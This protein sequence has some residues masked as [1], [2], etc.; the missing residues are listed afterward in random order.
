[1]AETWRN[2]TAVGG[3]PLAITDNLNFGNPEKPP[4]MGQIVEAI[5]GIGAACKGLDY[6]VIS[7][8]VSLYNET[9]GRPILPTPAIG[10]VGLLRDLN[11]AL[12]RS[13]VPRQMRARKNGAKSA[14]SLAIT[15]SWASNLGCSCHSATP[16]GCN[17]PR[18]RSR[19]CSSP[20]LLCVR[21]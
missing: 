18:T 4:I 16:S 1:M 2:I 7:G 11:R 14:L 21:C 19:G 10:G 17:M 13:T 20:G 8:N 6:P 9:D 5:R 3:L 12:V 15:R